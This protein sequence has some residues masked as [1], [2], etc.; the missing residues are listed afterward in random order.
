MGSMHGPLLVDVDTAQ[1]G[2]GGGALGC[3]LCGGKE[4]GISCSF[5]LAL[6]RAEILTDRGFQ[7]YDFFA[8]PVCHQC[9]EK[10]E[11]V[12][13]L[14][15]PPQHLLL[16][17]SAY[18]EIGTR[19]QMKPPL[20]DPEDNQILWQALKDGVIDFIATDRAPHTLEEKALRECPVWKL[21][22]PLC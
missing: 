18:E 19:T 5:L 17:T 9:G 10:A 12:N 6:E 13:T 20:R 21:P 4:K 2:D 7:E 11:G 1:L 22:C 14:E 8:S 15:V 3:S 16:N